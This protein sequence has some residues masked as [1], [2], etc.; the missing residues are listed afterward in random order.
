MKERLTSCYLHARRLAIR[1][2]RNAKEYYTR[3]VDYR[4]EKIIKRRY[5]VDYW[6]KLTN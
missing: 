2:P 6:I 3:V 1:D 4:L 5:G